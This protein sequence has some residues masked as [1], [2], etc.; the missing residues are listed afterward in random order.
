VNNPPP[1]T[2]SITINTIRGTIS[3]TPNRALLQTLPTNNPATLIEAALRIANQTREGLKQATISLHITI[4]TQD[5]ERYTNPTN[6]PHTTLS[7]TTQTTPSRLSTHTLELPAGLEPMPHQIRGA[8]KLVKQKIGL[9]AHAPGA[10]KTLTS[11][12]A[13]TNSKNDQ[14]VLIIAPPSTIGDV[15]Q[16][17]LQDWF[18]HLQPIILQGTK[19]DATLIP[20]EGILIIGWSVLHNWQEALQ[21]WPTLLIADEHHFAKSCTAKRT[22]A[23]ISLAAGRHTTST[24][25]TKTWD[26]QA[27]PKS[28]YLLSGTP[29]ANTPAELA[30][31]LMALNQLHPNAT[32]LN[33]TPRDFQLQYA[34]ERFF[35][36][37]HA[38]WGGSR[39]IDELHHRTKNIIDRQPKNSLNL[40]P[41]TTSE[42]RI[43]I[44]N[45]ELVELVTQELELWL[46]LHDEK[47]LTK[48][49]EET[50]RAIL[51]RI[52]KIVGE[53]KTPSIISHALN[54]LKTE[55]K[56][57]IFAWH[58]TVIE[59]IRTQLNQA[60]IKTTKIDGSVP[61]HKRLDIIND[62]QQGDTRVLVGQ[63]K[64]AGTG[65]TL[66]AARIMLI[67]EYP[68]TAADLTQS[69]DRIHRIGQTRAC[70]IHHITAADTIDE[71]VASML[72]TKHENLLKVLDGEKWQ[73]IN[74]TDTTN[75][76]DLLRTV[77]NR[78]RHNK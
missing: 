43:K 37:K 14:R 54:V 77:G 75:G 34:Y 42:I 7:W 67:A 18:P 62:F 65:L 30:P 46:S 58:K 28:V 10:G 17:T 11:L 71:L 45:P 59:E 4:N 9:L 69:E 27:P 24:S 68:W 6:H 1:T 8:Q 23:L 56:L 21:G 44:D 49:E 16:R 57:V 47:E 31:A 25:T 74:G 72:A 20:P 2:L 76:I 53:G 32:R 22:R 29:F 48:K 52:R 78:L 55:E 13:A 50:A 61:Q 35:D 15:W 63:H 41:K 40:P 5:P 51:V 38:G 19:P 33:E 70:E 64:A 3:H 39:N 66:H 26:E 36:G 73:E 60:N 12:I